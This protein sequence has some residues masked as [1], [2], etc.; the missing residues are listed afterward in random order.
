MATACV[1]CL[2]LK[3]GVLS[4]YDCGHSHRPAA[5]GGTEGGG[6]D[7]RKTAS[8]K[9][10]VGGVSDKY[11]AVAR[12][13]AAGA[14]GDTRVPAEH[15]VTACLRAIVCQTMMSNKRSTHGGMPWV[16]QAT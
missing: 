5:I 14:V 2:C 3:D 4:G 6:V 1:E 7:R 9:I 12:V 11:G 8:E 16:S 10:Q 13:P 15:P